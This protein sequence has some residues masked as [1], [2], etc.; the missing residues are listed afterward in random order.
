MRRLRFPSGVVGGRLA[1]DVT[2]EYD[3]G[4]V[5]G[6]V[7][8]IPTDGTAL[9]GIVAPGF[10]NA[11]SH[12]FHRALRGRTH[13][14]G[15][16]FWSWRDLMYRVANEL[17]PETYRRL[18]SGVFVE[19]LAAGITAVG[20]FHYVH[21]AAGGERYSDPNAMGR[22]LIQAAR[23]AGIRLTLIDTCYLSSDVAGNPLRPE[24]ARFS[25][26]SVE[27]WAERVRALAESIAD[28]PKVRL[29]VAA[30]SVRAVPAKDLPA[31][32]SLGDE[33]GVPIH[34][35]VSEQP[36]E[37]TACLDEHGIT[38]VELLVET[39]VLGPNSTAVHAT[40][41]SAR[42][43]ELIAASGAGVCLCPT[44]ERD[45][46]DG[47][48]VAVEL[49]AAGVPLS[50]GTDSNAVIDMFEEARSVEFHDRLRTGRRGCHDP[51]E[52]WE[53][54]A[55]GSARAIGWPELGRLEEGA[56]ADIVIIDP[57]SFALAGAETLAGVLF[58]ARRTDVSDVYVRGTQVIAHRRHAGSLGP[59]TL[60]GGLAAVLE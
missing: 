10:A 41:L 49:A 3:S 59:G 35:H 54:A 2:V 4:V 43:I 12:S 48:G 16:D 57:G 60:G 11:H 13:Q 38:P 29:A 36:A 19:M 27:A 5:T 37:N 51:A 39:G 46:A 24:Q 53:A 20:E 56:P 26:G 50:L 44:T 30:H 58:A 15:G 6:V 47:P 25:D 8:G 14:S 55:S 52:L 45:L 9:S 40:H 21:H 1:D 31:I 18:A 42:D 7:A 28:E 34:V 33:L 17:Y 23:D 22:A 32:R